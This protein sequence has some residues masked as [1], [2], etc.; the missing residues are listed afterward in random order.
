M[1]KKQPIFPTLNQI[2]PVHVLSSYFVRSISILSSLLC[3]GL[4]S[5]LFPSSLTTKSRAHCYSSLPWVGFIHVSS[6]CYIW[7][8]VRRIKTRLPSNTL[9]MGHMVQTFSYTTS[10]RC[11]CSWSGSLAASSLLTAWGKIFRSQ[12]TNTKTPFDPTFLPPHNSNKANADSHT[13]S[14]FLW[15]VIMDLC[16]FYE[17]WQYFVCVMHGYMFWCDWWS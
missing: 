15:D 12:T 14:N 5:S 10:F 4:P 7:H 1:H 16:T 11:I 9:S 2:N 13:L 8:F 6:I 3:L 17:R